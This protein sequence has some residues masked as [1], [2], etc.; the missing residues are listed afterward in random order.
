MNDTT[1]GVATMGMCQ[2]DAFQPSDWL[3][4]ARRWRCGT[5]R[6]LYIGVVDVVAIQPQGGY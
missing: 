5:V 2:G 3:K 1:L 4:G 6:Y